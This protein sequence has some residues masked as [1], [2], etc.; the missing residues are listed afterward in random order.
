M[1][2][3]RCESMSVRKLN[4]EE[5]VVVISA[6]ILTGESGDVIAPSKGREPGK[7]WS[8]SHRMMVTGNSA[9]IDSKIKRSSKR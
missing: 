2:I 3:S 9:L 4:P 1:E 7:N 8:I 6:V 5:M